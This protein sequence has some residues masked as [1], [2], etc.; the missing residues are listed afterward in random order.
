[1]Q[2]DKYAK[3]QLRPNKATRIEIT[4]ERTHPKYQLKFQSTSLATDTGHLELFRIEP[5]ER[6]LPTFSA[7]WDLK[8]NTI[9]I[10]LIGN[11]EA[12]EAFKAAVDGYNGHHTVIVSDSPRVYRVDIQTPMG[13]VFVGKV[14]VAIELGLHLRDSLENLREQIKDELRILAECQYCGLVE[15]SGPPFVFDRCPKCRRDLRTDPTPYNGA[16]GSILLAG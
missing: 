3:I 16:F 12:S 1:M 5:L 7:R 13:V 9:D 11:A 6:V 10:D 15:V 8:P 4:P 2:R 14:E